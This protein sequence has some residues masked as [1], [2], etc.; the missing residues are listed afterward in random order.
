V[1]IELASVEGGA[2]N[3]TEDSVEFKGTSDKKDYELKFKVAKKIDPA[4]SSW[5][6][7]DRGVE[8]S[9]AKAEKGFWERIL[10]DEDKGRLKQRIKVDW[11]LWRDEGKDNSI[12]YN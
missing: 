3:F 4:A 5:A 6:A 7:K 8:V 9:L 1:T 11:D 12:L 2:V 10:A